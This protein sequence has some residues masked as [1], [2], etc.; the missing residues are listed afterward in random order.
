MTNFYVAAFAALT[1][2]NVVLCVALLLRRGIIDCRRIA[3]VA[4][5]LLVANGLQMIAL[6]PFRLSW[7]GRAHMAW[8][9]LAIVVPAC[10]IALLVALR[11]GRT[12]SAGAILVGLA[13][14]VMIP[15]AV[16][17]WFITPFDLR[18]ERVDISLAEHHTGTS[19]VRIGVLADIQ[20]TS[21]GPHERRAIDRLMAEE[22][23][24]IL[25]PGDLYQG[26]VQE[27]EQH[28]P[29]FRELLQRLHAPGGVWAVSGNSDYKPGLQRM[30]QDTE[31]RLLDNELVRF[32]VGD[33]KIALL[34]M[35]DWPSLSRQGWQ[36]L[37]GIV[38][39]FATR[40]AGDEIRLLLAHRPGWVLAL[41]EK[42]SI[43]LTVSGHT[44]GGQVALPLL[45][46]PLVLSAL[47]NSVGAGGLH[48]VNGQRLYISR[49]LGMERLQ[50]P[51]IRFGVAPEVTLLTLRS[52][53][54]S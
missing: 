4:A 47:P 45:G 31:V 48:E 12:A 41:P 33:R 11:R 20:A 34:G 13:G 35:A 1:A 36:F 39:R 17:A 26:P 53:G 32:R 42:S 44:H 46:P 23:D 38:E 37:P 28:L 7:F 8:L 29:G 9:D 3:A 14:L 50:A 25:I 49:G 2:L 10:S 30:L 40:P 51:R 24:V 16:Q 54:D 43:D 22:P 52:R 6:T 27:F 15:V 5:A 18:L 19:P 21:I